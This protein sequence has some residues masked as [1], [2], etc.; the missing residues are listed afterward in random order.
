MVFIYINNL[1]KN[2]GNMDWNE[3]R[4][5]YFIGIHKNLTEAAKVVGATQ[6]NMSRVIKSLET[7]LGKKLT[8]KTHKGILL[9]SDG[10]A[11]FKTASNVFKEI[12]LAE[13]NFSG[14]P[15]DS[16]SRV[17]LRVASS[18]GLSS[19]WLSR[20][21]PEFIESHPNIRI[22]LKSSSDSLEYK[23]KEVD[24]VIGPN[25][26]VRNDLKQIYIKSFYF[27]LF[28]SQTYIERFGKPI[29]PS[30]LDNHRLIGFS[31]GNHGAF[32]ESESLLSLGTPNSQSRQSYVEINSNTGEAN[33]ASSGIGI[34]SIEINLVKRS[35]PNLVRL[36]PDF[37]PVEVKT[38]C[39][40]PKE[41]QNS[42]KIRVFSQFLKEKGEESE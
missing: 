25:I 11:L 39:I 8:Q 41:S 28:A 19:G 7:K 14:H 23:I 31:G 37:S 10:E 5:F 2:V 4:N 33:L 32:I 17:D 40:F 18:P 42:E 38:Y 34:A 24:L 6:S 30:D 35:Y 1:Y 21:L 29:I 9:T 3:L 13:S 36:L 16:N 26:Q 15:S 27:A 20:I 22:L 12:Q